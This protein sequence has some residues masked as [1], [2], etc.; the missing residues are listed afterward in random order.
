MQSRIIGTGACVPDDVLTN[1][2]IE[3]LVDT[4]DEW[5]VSRT[6]IR[7]RRRTGGTEASSDLAYKA[8]RYALRDAGVKAGEVDLVLVAT[9]TPDMLLP[10]TACIVQDRLGLKN[11]PAFDLSAACT[12]FI[13][14]L[15]T[16]DAFIRSG[17]YGTILLIGVDTLTKFT[18][19]G[20]RTTCVIFGDGAGAVVVK[21]IREKRGVIGSMLYADGDKWDYIYVPAGGSRIPSYAADKTTWYLR[22]KGHD[23]FKVAVRG[24]EQAII[25]LL[26]RYRVPIEDI[27]I[28]IPH[29][30]N[31]RIIEALT[32]KLGYP[33]EKVFV[34]IQKYGNTSAASIPIALDEAVRQGRIKSGDT[35]LLTAFGSGLTWGASLIKW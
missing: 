5:I 26:E 8:A 29:Q 14:G 18:D 25:G 19:Y 7:E 30:A 33:P 10:S 22:M 1:E 9:T 16:A 4:S 12:G 13:Y 34:N 15:S 27:D 35:V 6:G 3:R 24:L 2:A 21:A 20:D 23:T 31:V 11:V 28:V 17:A 32:R